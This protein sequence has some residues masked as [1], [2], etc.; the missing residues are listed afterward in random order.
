[1]PPASNLK[2]QQTGNLRTETLVEHAPA[3]QL[4]RGFDQIQRSVHNHVFLSAGHPPAAE[5]HEDVPRVDA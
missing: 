4:F 3:Y 2:Y 5:Y 1:M